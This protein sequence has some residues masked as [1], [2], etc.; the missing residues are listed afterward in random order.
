MPRIT[1]HRVYKDAYRP[2]Q[3]GRQELSFGIRCL[4]CART[5][6]RFSQRGVPDQTIRPDVLHFDLKLILVTA[7]SRS[8]EL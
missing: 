6:L 7:I 1:G 5:T 3:A 2:E 8:K 4:I